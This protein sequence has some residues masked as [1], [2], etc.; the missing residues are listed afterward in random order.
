MF[1]GAK[2]F[3]QTKIVEKNTANGVLRDVVQ[4]LDRGVRLPSK[5]HTVLRYTRKCN[6]IYAHKNS[7]AFLGAGFHEFHKRSAALGLRAN[8]LYRISSKSHNVGS[9]D[10]NYFMP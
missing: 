2:N 6:F 4:R 9:V 7:T 3:F 10:R 8:L 1:I 5:C